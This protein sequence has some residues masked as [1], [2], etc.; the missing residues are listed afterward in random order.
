MHQPLQLY[1]KWNDSFLKKELNNAVKELKRIADYQITNGS[2]MIIN[3]I[4]VGVACN[5][6]KQ[7][8]TDLET[9]AFA[10]LQYYSIFIIRN[11]HPWYILF[12][13]YSTIL[14]IN[15]IKNLINH[16]ITMTISVNSVFAR[17]LVV[18]LSICHDRSISGH[19]R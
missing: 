3:I 4:N 17:V 13:Y 9:A 16:N 14:V 12:S 19:V 7:A 11:S 18:I 6:A 2:G 10:L 8:P 15:I 5:A 1:H